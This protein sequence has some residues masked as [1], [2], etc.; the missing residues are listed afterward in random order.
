MGKA[1]RGSREITREQKL[2]SENKA[3]KRDLGRIRKELA[4]LDLDRYDT[5]K[6]MIEE[7]KTESEPE[8]GAQ[9][10]ENLKKTWL[11]NDCR[12]GHL[13]IVLFTK[14]ANTM[15]YRRCSNEEC[16]NRTK[17][18]KYTPQVTGLMKKVAK[19]DE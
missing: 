9:F 10:L 19:N 16:V 12:Q 6:E 11:C 7:N 1:R 18:Q 14:L 2:I 8:F 13:E 4:R 3:L 17:S 15:Y 5:L